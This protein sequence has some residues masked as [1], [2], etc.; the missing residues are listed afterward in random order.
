MLDVAVWRRFEE[1]LLFERPNLEQ[2]RRLLALKLRGVRREFEVEDTAVTT[3]FKGMTHADVERVLRRAIK[4]MVLGG[5]EFLTKSHLE[6][7]VK[8]EKPRH[9]RNRHK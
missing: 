7:A 2:L 9:V 4:D 3:L 8:R 5:K 1:V 6:S